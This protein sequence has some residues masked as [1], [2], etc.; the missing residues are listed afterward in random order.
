MT[1]QIVIYASITAAVV[2]ILTTVVLKAMGMDNAAVTGGA[3]A[4]GVVGAL[5]PMWRARQDSE[6]PR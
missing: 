5:V 2:A 4:G 6:P 1:K 3:V